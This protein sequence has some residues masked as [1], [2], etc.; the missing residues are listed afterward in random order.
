ML[1]ELAPP[2]LCM[3]WNPD[4]DQKKAGL[5]ELWVWILT[6]QVNP[7]TD[8]DP[9]SIRIQGFDEH[10]WRKKYVKIFFIFFSKI[11]IPRAPLRTSKLRENPSALKR[12]HPVLK[13][14]K[15]I[16]FSYIF[17]G[18]FCQPGSGSGCESGSGYGSRDTAEYGSTTMRVS[19][20]LFKLEKLPCQYDEAQK[21]KWDT[22]RLVT[23]L[24]GPEA[25]LPL[26]FS[27]LP[28]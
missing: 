25:L 13:K 24:A 9:D 2:V 6:F 28:C 7:D 19:K 23:D 8:L 26:V 17:A 16:N 10:N 18:H 14:I 27:L 22:R 12:E 5:Q 11:A 21:N 15:F 4:P 1:A 20:T 3:L